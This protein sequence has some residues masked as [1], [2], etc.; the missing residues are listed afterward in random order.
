[1]GTFSKDQMIKHHI[2]CHDDEELLKF[3]ILR[4]RLMKMN[5]SLNYRQNTTSS[6]QNIFYQME[7]DR[8]LLNSEARNLLDNLIDES[9]ILQESILRSQVTKV[10]DFAK[11]LSRVLDFKTQTSSVFYKLLES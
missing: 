10:T 11:V 3:S 2:K 4:Q 8:Q 1:M 6:C 7:Y 5:V 9:L